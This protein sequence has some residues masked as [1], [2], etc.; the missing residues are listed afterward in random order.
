MINAHQFRSFAKHAA[1]ATEIAKRP[2]VSGL[3]MPRIATP[4][5]GTGKLPGKTPKNPFRVNWKKLGGLA[6]GLVGVGVLGTGAAAAGLGV[7]A[8]LQDPQKIQKKPKPLAAR[9]VQSASSGDPRKL[10]E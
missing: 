4:R 3:K 10:F 2:R 6:P 7:K 1:M 9:V 5:I 8:A